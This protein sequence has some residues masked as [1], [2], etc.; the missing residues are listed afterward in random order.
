MLNN[1]E[2]KHTGTKFA[3]SR[4]MEKLRPAIE[5]MVTKKEDFKTCKECGEPTSQ[6][7]CKPC[8]MLQQIR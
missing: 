4:T 3:I 7:Q 8:E 5:Q 6:E 2:E 1:I